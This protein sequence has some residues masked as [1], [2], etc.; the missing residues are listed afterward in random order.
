MKKSVAAPGGD[1]H[2]RKPMRVTFIPE[3]TLTFTSCHN[4][5]CD[6]GGVRITNWTYTAS[7]PTNRKRK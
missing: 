7:T 1:K 5:G 2:R 3:A 6:S 4:G